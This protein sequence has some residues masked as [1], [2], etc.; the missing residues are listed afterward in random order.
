MAPYRILALD[1]GG[2]KGVLTAAL[3]ERIEAA[4]P[5]FLSKVDLFAGTSTGGILA[6]GLASGLTPAQCR[7]FYESDG[8][9]VFKTPLW[10]RAGNLVVAKY[11]NGALKAALVRQFGN[12]TLGELPRR[13]LIAS[14]DLD[15][16]PANPNTVRTW[17]PKFFHNYPGP[18]TDA[19]EKIVNVALYTSAAPTYFP[20]HQGYIDGGVVANTPSVCAL[21]QAL[22][23]QTGKQQLDDV[24]LLSLGTGRS[25]RHLQ[26]ENADWGVLPWAY[27]LIHLI[28]EEGSSGTA[29][30]QCRQILGDRYYRLNPVLPEPIALDDVDLIPRL[31]D[32]AERADLTEVLEWLVTGDQRKTLWHWFSA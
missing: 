4:R 10:R 5:G 24:V 18:G 8:P 31:K 7:E 1:G 29:D 27:P 21:A 19:N 9:Q 3:L 32:V 20:V 17:K 12:R 26:A 6:L 30:Y 2:I 11:A 25:V 13:V 15:N 14:F 23:K 22:D 16:N 28:L